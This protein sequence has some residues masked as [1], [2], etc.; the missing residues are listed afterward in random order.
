MAYVIAYDIGTTGIK[1]CIFAI[2]ETIKLVASA[3]DGYNLYVLD[4]GG[5][6]QDVEEWWNAF[7]KTTA[8]VLKKSGLKGEQIAGLSFC[9]QMQGLILVDEKGVPVHRPMSYMDQRATEEIKKGIANGFMI[10][11]ANVFK[12]IPSL[13]I[14][15]AVSSSVK[16]P[17]WKYKWIEAHEPDNFARAR[18]WLDVKE[19]FIG[20][21]TNEF[22]MTEDSAFSTLL[23]DTRK[24]RC[25]WS[26]K[27][28]QM[29]K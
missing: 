21:C 2:E 26:K 13:L 17:L 11:G 23:Y 29:V 7:K 8:A 5:V 20:R 27:M 3:S 22:I 12:L 1:T 10:A 9:S 16:D 14:T 24:G 4:N 15:G 18:W 28:C 6:E 25:G 19:Y